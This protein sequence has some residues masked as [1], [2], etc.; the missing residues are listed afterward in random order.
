MPI[1]AADRDEV[2]F[3]RSSGNVFADLGLPNPDV[4]LAKADLSFQIAA[5]IDERGW[6]SDAAAAA[7]GF[8]PGELARV[9]QGDLMDVPLERLLH[10]LTKFGRDVEIAVAPA[11]SERGSLAVRGA[12]D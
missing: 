9:F 3:E 6:S 2:S 11:A 1:N 10:V 4:A 5:L 8:G 7:L 12:A